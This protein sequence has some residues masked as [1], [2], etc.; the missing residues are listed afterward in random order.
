MTILPYCVVLGDTAGHLPATGI[1]N[2]KLNEFAEAGLTAVYSQIEKF[3]IS[4]TNFQQAALEFHNVVHAMFAHTAVVP[5]RFPTWLSEA[6]LQRHLRSES[7]RY[8]R[9]LNQHANHVQMEARIRLEQSSQGAASSSG[10]EHLRTR[11]AQIRKL[12]DMA[13]HT[14]QAVAAEAIEW[15]ERET[16]DGLRLYA[17]VDRGKLASFREKL[18]QADSGVRVSGPW[19][20]TEFLEPRVG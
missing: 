5:F 14:K 19:P 11:A 1:L 15:R 4:V 7:A 9:F 2:S 13:E 17:L 6:E 3:D 8:Q 18:S 10:T 12:R 16:P 20:A